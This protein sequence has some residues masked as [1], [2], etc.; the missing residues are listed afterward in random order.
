MKHLFWT[1]GLFLVGC[2]SSDKLVVYS[3][4]GGEMLGDYEELFEAAY[5][6]VDVQLLDMGSKDVYSRIR[7]EKNRP[8]CDVWWGAPSTMFMQAADEGL[9]AP[10]TPTWCNA[11]DLQFRDPEFRWH[12]TYRSPLAIMFNDRQYKAEDM[13]QTWD[14]LLTEP[15]KGKISLRK[16][17]ESGTMRTFIGAMISRAPSEDAGIAWLAKLH[18]ATGEYLGN[19]NLLFDHIKK[20]PENISV[21]LMPDVVMQAVRNGFPFGYHIPKG[22]PVLTDGIAI[23]EGAPH[24]EWAEKFYEFVTTKEALVHQASA[25]AKLPARNDIDPSTLPPKL[26][27]QQVDAMNINW[28][29]FAIKEKDWCNR[30]KTEVFEAQ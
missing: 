28:N 20:N 10:Y 13:P 23:V 19:P 14:D 4:H 18:A 30:W 7:A 11:V 6:N 22:T 2:S 8:Q 27:T 26:I 24:R 15:W 25:Y 17:L 5:P 21:W 16:P 3:P 9:L 1:L 12:A 29:E